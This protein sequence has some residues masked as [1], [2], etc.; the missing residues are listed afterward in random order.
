MKEEL[1][2]YE[3]KKINGGAVHWGFVVAGIGAGI[4][5]LIGVIDGYLRPY[6]CRK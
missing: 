4:A 1:T 6:A 2:N 3:L 5:F